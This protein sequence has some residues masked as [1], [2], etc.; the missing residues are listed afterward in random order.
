M[1]VQTPFISPCVG[2]AQ[3]AT[4]SSSLSCS[5]SSSAVRRVSR[6]S[7]VSAS[8]EPAVPL[9]MDGDGLGHRIDDPVLEHAVSA[10]QLV[11]VAQIP[12][13]GGRREDLDHEVGY[14]PY[15]VVG[16]R[17]LAQRFGRLG[18]VVDEPP[19]RGRR[20]GGHRRLLAHPLAGPHRRRHRGATAPRPARQATP[21]PKRPMSRTAAGSHA[22]ASSDWD[23][24]VSFRTSSFATSAR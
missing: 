11:L 17:V 19:R 15:V 14:S 16:E 13:G 12:V 2:I 1:S 7:K 21:R 9:P 23:G 8:F 22:C 24:P 3:L 5:P 18:R 10:V 20:H 6:R 4:M